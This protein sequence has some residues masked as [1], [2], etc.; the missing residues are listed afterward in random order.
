V[1]ATVLSVS[2]VPARAAEWLTE[3]KV[4]HKNPNDVDRLRSKV[5]EYLEDLFTDDELLEKKRLADQAWSRLVERYLSDI[6]KR[7]KAA[8]LLPPINMPVIEQ[9]GTKKYVVYLFDFE[10]A[11]ALKTFSVDDDSLGVASLYSCEGNPFTLLAINKS[12]FSYAEKTATGVSLEKLLYSTLAHELFHTVQFTYD[13]KFGSTQMCSYYSDVVVEGMA[14]GV[15][16]YMVNQ[17]W[18]GFLRQSADENPVGLYRYRESFLQE[19]LDDE[20]DERGS[21]RTS[22]F[23]R[24]LVERFGGFAFLGH[25][26]KQPIVKDPSSDDVQDWLQR[27][28]K[29]WP[30]FGWGMYT[31]FPA[32]LTEFT[33]SAD[34]QYGNWKSVSRYEYWNEDR[35]TKE[36]FVRC[37]KAELTPEE[38]VKSL[39]Y[40]MINKVAG[41]CAIIRWAG[42]L[43]QIELEFE[44]RSQSLSLLDQVHLGVARA[45][46]T[47]LS[48]WDTYYNCYKWLSEPGRYNNPLASCEYEKTF[49]GTGPVPGMYAKRWIG[50]HHMINSV[51]GEILF[52]L[53]NVAPDSKKT[54]AINE[55]NKNDVEFWVGIKYTKSES[56]QRPMKPAKTLQLRVPDL[57]KMDEVT[58]GINK[59]KPMKTGSNLPVFDLEVPQG[60]DDGEDVPPAAKYSVLPLDK[61]PIV[62]GYKGPLYGMV[63][64]EY[65]D[66]YQNRPVTSMLCKNANKG[67][68]GQVLRA[69]AEIMV[70]HV[71]S[72]LCLM[73]NRP[74]QRPKVV[75]R[76][77]A[78]ITLPF[79]WRYFAKTA[80]IDIVTPGTRHYIKRYQQRLAG[81]G[82]PGGRPGQGPGGPP[83]GQSGPSS[84]GGRPGQ[85]PEGPPAGQSGPSSPG[86]GSP[87]GGAGAS[88][89]ACQCSCEEYEKM[90]ALG[91]AGGPEAEQQLMGYAPCTMQCL[92]AYM[93][94]ASEKPG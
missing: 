27:G 89:P 84:P 31:M 18:P 46:T 7:Y 9:D 38:P 54:S 64:A 47:N 39:Y 69:D 56:G 86:V 58:Y 20:L 71:K 36:V 62:P 22:S 43:G 61:Q 50:N 3:F 2:T 19:P 67:L 59:G 70:V 52:V 41:D 49:V 57:G 28:L 34:V 72:N 29:S 55:G 83:G 5:G 94:C 60:E 40:P 85:G 6:A 4:V 10:G 12:E 45:R 53:A 76:L 8:G 77:D 79:G 16:A 14:E 25:L 78:T 24:D 37:L 74:N 1:L 32:F 88:R 82:L 91:K 51:Q 80:P 92:S 63:A 23:W 33:G 75:D 30:Q 73:P 65:N 15:D 26:L 48:G 90:Q 21:Y 35:L 13:I 81:M 11:T 66:K 93:R 68:I 42:F 87:G 17:R 44:A